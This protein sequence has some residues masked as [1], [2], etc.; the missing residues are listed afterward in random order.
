MLFD[1]NGY[2]KSSQEKEGEKM[3]NVEMKKD[4]TKVLS[5]KLI[6]II[7]VGVAILVVLLV[8]ILV[9]VN[10]KYT[11]ELGEYVTVEFAG[12]DKYGTIE[13]DYND[14]A[15]MV[16]YLRHGEITETNKDLLT[17]IS[18]QLKK[19]DGDNSDEMVIDA[20][21]DWELGLDFYDEERLDM[22]YDDIDE[23][24]EY[25]VD[26]EESLCNGD[27]V[28]ISFSYDE[29]IAEKLGFNIV[30]DEKVFVVENL[31]DAVEIDVFENIEV[32]FSGTSP[33]VEATITEHNED[34]SSYVEF[35]LSKEENIRK[36]ETIILTAEVEDQNLMEDKGYHVSNKIMEY[37]CDE[38]DAYAS[39]LEEIPQ[40]MVD[41][42]K[43]QAEDAFNAYVAREWVED[44]KV[45]KF[46]CIGNYML[47]P[48][49]GV[50]DVD[51]NRIY[52]VHKVKVN[53]PE[54]GDFTYYYYTC[55]YNGIVLKDGTFSID[56]TNYNVPESGGWFTEGEEFE[57][58]G[59]YYTGYEELESLF[60]H[61]V[62]ES[63]E[64]YNYE[65]TVK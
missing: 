39:K 20:L 24:F 19:M 55:F 8:I 44:A 54:A 28:T 38:V 6:G 56:L 25:S 49:E 51:A 33:Y 15:L 43:Q 31:P 17:P 5:K 40:D 63:I 41:K 34:L 30:D 3:E 60:N 13:V 2:L 14:D 62:T 52:L 10:R 32:T 50:T 35:E 4:F 65:S 45:K 27:K 16:A 23:L 7:A 22:V 57:K 12:C 9:A 29:I 61:C 47:V 42:M 18:K 11:V 53:N 37:T 1:V 64:Y 36:G 48:K 46:E 59:L 21:T 58:G 26:K